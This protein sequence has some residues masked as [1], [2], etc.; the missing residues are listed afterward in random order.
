MKRLILI[1]E[2]ERPDTYYLIEALK[3][4]LLEALD[5]ED[6]YDPEFADD[7]YLDMFDEDEK[8][9]LLA[10]VEEFTSGND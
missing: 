7:P 6:P 8:Q 5:M 2:A 10:A 3:R 1:D 9:A 4:R